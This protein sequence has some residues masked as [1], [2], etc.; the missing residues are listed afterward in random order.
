MARCINQPTP[1]WRHGVPPSRRQKSATF[2]L[3]ESS[4][5]RFHDQFAMHFWREVLLRSTAGSRI[6]AGSRF[7]FEAK[8]TSNT[9]YGL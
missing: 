3:V 8:M 5:F 6:Q 9:H 4:T 1:V 7:G 2:I